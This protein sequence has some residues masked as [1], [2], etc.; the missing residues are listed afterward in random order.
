MFFASK[1]EFMDLVRRV[2]RLE[3]AS[4][5]PTGAAKD[6]SGKREGLFVYE[7]ILR[8]MSDGVVRNI[9]Q[10]ARAVNKSGLCKRSDRY[11]IGIIT[12]SLA[13]SGQLQRVRRGV[14]RMV[15]NG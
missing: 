6:V 5:N 8:V 15:S 9:R 1:R 13:K 2:E 4:K 7:A 12:P 11:H 10:I 3:R 14:Y